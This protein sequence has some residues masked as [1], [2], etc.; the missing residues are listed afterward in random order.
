[1]WLRRYGLS[2]SAGTLPLK[3]ATG[4]A[5]YDRARTKLFTLLRDALGSR[6][7]AEQALE[8]IFVLYAKECAGPQQPTVRHSPTAK[9]GAMGSC[10]RGR[11]RIA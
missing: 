10:A 1:M 8:A 6:P 5:V 2:R 4:R 3:E 7:A 11:M 9:R